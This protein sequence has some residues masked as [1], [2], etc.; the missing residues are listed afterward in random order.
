M[1][2]NEM[3]VEYLQSL[4]LVKRKYDFDFLQDAIARH[5]GTFAF[6]SVGCWLR[7]ELP[8]DFESLY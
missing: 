1:K 4:A 7:D 3:V 8:L 2:N 6:S 5:I